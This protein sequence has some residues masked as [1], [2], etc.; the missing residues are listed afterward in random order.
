MSIKT[1]QLFLGMTAAI[2]TYAVSPGWAAP[3]V[4]TVVPSGSTYDTTMAV[5]SNFYGPAQDLA[6]SFIT[7][8]PAGSG[9]KI[10]VCQNSTGALDAEI[11]GG[12]A[13]SLFMAANTGSP[14][15]LYDDGYNASGASPFNYALGIPVLWSTVLTTAQLTTPSG[16]SSFGFIVDTSNVTSLA[17]ADPNVA[18]YGA[19]AVDILTEMGQWP[20]AT[21]WITQYDNISLTYDAINAGT[22]KAGFVS[23]AQIC[24]NIGSAQYVQFTGSD[25]T[26]EQAGLL[27]NAGTVSQKSLAA[28]IKSYLMNPT[29][30]SSFLSA[31]CYLA[32]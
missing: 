24:T 23:K 27:I 19:A 22:K 25:Y 29:Y 1:R 2:L 13:Y 9:K 31:H 5:A 30:L 18:P 15:G 7:N 21:G 10:R 11:R 3:T 16:S 12:A 20:G 32:P 28:S 14:Q 17:I 8:D 26:I 4:C 6:A